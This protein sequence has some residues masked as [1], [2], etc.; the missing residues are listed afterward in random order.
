M[1]I[2][3]ASFDPH[4]SPLRKA[5]ASGKMGRFIDEGSWMMVLTRMAAVLVMEWKRRK[6]RRPRSEA[7]GVEVLHK[8][9]LCL[10]FFEFLVG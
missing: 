4:E 6:D 3:S 10:F 7:I 5:G 1:R 2:L 8:A 9:I